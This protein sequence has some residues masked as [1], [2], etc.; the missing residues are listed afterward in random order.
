[1]LELCMNRE[2]A[3][4]FE[5]CPHD[6]CAILGGGQAMCLCGMGEGHQQFVEQSKHQTLA[7]N[8]KQ[9]FLQSYVT[10]SVSPPQE[11]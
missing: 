6:H 4:S 9:V 8:G 7:F 5:S 11:K 3:Q 1:M 10:K 2:A